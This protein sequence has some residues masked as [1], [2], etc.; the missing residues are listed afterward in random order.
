[1]VESSRLMTSCLH[2]AET[3]AMKTPQDVAAILKLH[4]LG[5]GKKAIPRALGINKNTARRY[6]EAGGMLEYAKPQRSSRLEGQEEWLAQEL[7]KHRGNADVVR[8]ELE[9]QKG[10]QVSLRTVQRAVQENRVAIEAEAKATLRFETPPG[11]QAQADFGTMRV[12]IGGERVQV[13][14]FV[15]T[16]GSPDGYLWRPSWMKR[17]APGRLGWSEPSCI[18]RGL[19]TRC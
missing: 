10:I 5:W 18:S 16:L 9:R 19:P 6:L 17:G 8:Q 3:E 13:H 11:L 4:Q 15:M 12:Q 1:M 7:R 2:A 14:L